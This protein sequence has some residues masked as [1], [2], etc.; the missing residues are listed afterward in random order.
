MVLVNAIYF[1]GDWMQPFDEA[2]TNE[3]GIF[4]QEDGTELT[5]PIM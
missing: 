3:Q 4:V 1:K 2:S 5:T